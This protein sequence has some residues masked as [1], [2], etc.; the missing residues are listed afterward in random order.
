MTIEQIELRRLR[1][2]LKAS[3]ETSFGRMDHRE[4]I[5]LTVFS[6]GLRGH[7]E[8][9][10][11]SQPF[12]NEE[13][14]VTAWH[15]L[16]DFLIPRALGRSLENPEETAGWFVGI[17]RNHM[18]V[19][20][21]ESALW[22]LHSK[23]RGISLSSALGGTRPEI[24][25]GVSIGIESTIGRV[26]DNVERFLAEGYQKIKVKIKPGFDV[27]L[28]AAI[29]E[30]FGFE[31]P[32]MADANSAYTLADIPRIKQLDAFGLMMIEQ[33]LGHDDLIDHARLQQE[34]QTPICLD[35]SIHTMEDARKAIEMGSGRIINIKICRVGGLARARAIH[36]L[37]ARHGIPVW[38]G[39]MLELGV[40]RAH[41]IA[42]ASLPNFSIA[43]DTSA[44]ERSYA[45]DII[46]PAIDFSRP[47]W[48]PVPTAPGIGCEV[49][50]DVVEKFTIARK[51]CPRT[52]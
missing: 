7:A 15:I 14:T 1:V 2:P 37:C 34:I 50:P 21:L 17:R 43:G 41:N 22:D 29:R 16:E 18:A 46:T 35:E 40:G 11:F 20:A 36:D 52:T 38:C 45:E 26:L 49:L 13:T 25:A 51:T 48:I 44:S 4:T 39:G 23:A 32:L 27:S 6:E 9:L 3:F 30:K 47:G 42:L 10:A 31:V 24:A 5:L 33:P 28:I 12:Y 19:S 8:A